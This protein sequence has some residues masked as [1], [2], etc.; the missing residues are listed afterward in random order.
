MSSTSS[1]KFTA[2]IEGL[3]DPIQTS[4]QTFSALPGEDCSKFLKAFESA[5]QLCGWNAQASAAVLTALIQGPAVEIIAGSRTAAAIIKALTDHFYPETNYEI[6]YNKIKFIKK[7]KNESVQ[8]FYLRF[9]RDIQRLEPCMR[10]ERLT[11][12]AFLVSFST[13]F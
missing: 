6:Y 2:T 1:L 3:A 11:R 12:K 5:K 7:R 8:E 9:S 13:S 4:V 10:N